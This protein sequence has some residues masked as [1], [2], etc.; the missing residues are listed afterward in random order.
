MLNE[1]QKHLVEKIG[2]MHESEGLSPAVARVMGLLLVSNK[3]ELTFDEIRETLNLSKSAT[4]N[5]LNIS[6]KLNRVEY[7]TKPGDRKRYFKSKIELW[8]D[9]IMDEFADK[10][11][12]AC[13]FQE[14]LE[15][16]TNETKE[17]NKAIK[18]F[19]LF[20]EYLGKELPKLYK[21]WETKTK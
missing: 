20:L 16:R 21:Q 8:R 1:E 6:M 19:I 2:L 12:R 5:A 9:H 4:S 15:N 10:C 14:V 17:F 13:M 3:V 18:E 7:I 11:G